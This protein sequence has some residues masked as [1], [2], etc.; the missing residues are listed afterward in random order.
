MD[1]GTSGQFGQD[2]AWHG[3][4]EEVHMLENL[5]K[6][7]AADGGEAKGFHG[8]PDDPGPQDW[9]DYNIKTD[10]DGNVT[11]FEEKD[12]EAKDADKDGEISDAERAEWDKKKKE[13]YDAAGA[14]GEVDTPPDWDDSPHDDV[15]DEDFERDCWQCEKAR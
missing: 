11:G 4:S 5:T 6:G 1:A 12:L 7:K 2:V 14:P 10:K 15:P 9:S 8:D 3:T 13:E